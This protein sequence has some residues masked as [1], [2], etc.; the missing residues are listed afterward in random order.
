MTNGARFNPL[1]HLQSNLW[2][3]KAHSYEDDKDQRKDK[4]RD[5]D[6]D[7]RSAEQ[8]PKETCSCI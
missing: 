3:P 4:D 1:H 8:I 6:K 2:Q 5:K 7:K